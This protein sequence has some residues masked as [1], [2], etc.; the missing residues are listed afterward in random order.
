M[1][2]KSN[3]EMSTHR[4][5]LMLKQTRD[6]QTHLQNQIHDLETSLRVTNMRIA[7]L[8]SKEIFDTFVE[9]QRR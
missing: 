2:N 1:K 3:D 8:E 4:L 5:E 9:G 6:F 7:D